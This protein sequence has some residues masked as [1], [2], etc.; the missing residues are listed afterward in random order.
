MRIIPVDQIE[1]GMIL[2]SHVY[3]I[4][5]RLLISKGERIK[6]EHI[7]ILKI[8]GIPEVKIVGAESNEDHDDFLMDEEKIDQKK[9][10]LQKLF[11]YVDLKHPAIKE[12]FRLSIKY[13][14]AT[15]NQIKD[16]EKAQPKNQEIKNLQNDTYLKIKN[17]QIK[18]PVTPMIV[19][20]LNSIIDSPYSRADDIAMVVKKSPSLSALLLKIVN[21]A[22]YNF[23][24]KIDSIPWAVT[25]IGTKEIVN[26]ALGITVLEVFKDIPKTIVD[27]QSF[28]EHSF[29]CG[30][31]SRILG[32]HKNIGQTEQM[33]IS[34]LLHDIGRLVT[35]KYFPGQSKKLLQLSSDLNQPLYQ[36][37]NEYA[38]IRHTHIAKYLLQEWKLPIGL[39]NN[40]FYHHNPS[41]AQDPIKAGIV[42]I[43]DIIVLGLGFGSSGERFIPVFDEAVW[44]KLQ[45]TP[46][47]FESVIQ[48]TI[49]QLKFLSI[50]YQGES[51]L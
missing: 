16:E 32:A 22:F 34:G 3:D 7:R 24:E 40:I 50:F 23:P 18:L 45:M 39:L 33:F 31:L 35:Y 30:V 51:K 29:A 37:E 41:G 10:N 4:N 15:L 20:E 25:L 2:A 21:S 27:M 8:W 13:R 1:K 6:P 43:S 14:S 9:K 28:M 36:V 11:Q 48:Q 47:I 26:L 49:H 19:S 12:I 5:S 42:H 17:T 46:N 38:G 44:D